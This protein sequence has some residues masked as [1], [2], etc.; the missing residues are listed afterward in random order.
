MKNQKKWLTKRAALAMVAVMVLL[1]GSMSV[2][3]AEG[4][5]SKTKH[6]ND[7]KVHVK[8]QLNAQ[9]LKALLDAK[10]LV[11]VLDARGATSDRIP[12]AIAL[13]YDA[14]KKAIEKVV[15]DTNS[16][17]V[18]YCGGP[19]CPMSQML[20]DSLAK[21][22]YKNVVSF[23]GGVEQWKEAGFEL[24]TSKGDAPAKGSHSKNSSGSG[25]H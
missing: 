25:T 24:D 7:K 2:A 8:A 23:A 12:G 15:A 6:E 10:L 11:V 3:L 13:S 1:M 18:T 19:E 9:A 17:I 21:H 22:G 5:G 20:A 14:D 4:S 16:F